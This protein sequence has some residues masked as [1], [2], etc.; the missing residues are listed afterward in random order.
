M[1][2]AKPKINVKSYGSIFGD[3]PANEPNA[4]DIVNV[5]LNKL[6]SFDKHPFKVRDDDDMSEL[7]ASIAAEGV[8]NPILV[9]AY[10]ADG[11]YQIIA[12]HRRKR[13]AEIAGLTVIPAIVRDLDDDAAIAFMVDTNLARTK[14]LPSEKAWAYKMK[15]D[16]MKR[17]AGRKNSNF[18]PLEQNYPN[19]SSREQLAEQ[20]GESQAQ[21]RRYIRLTELIPAL[22]N[23]ADAEQ[24]SVRAGVE[25]SYIPGAEQELIESQIAEYEDSTSKIFTLSMKHAEALRSFAERLDEERVRGILFGLPK[26]KAPVPAKLKLNAS[27]IRGFFPDDA[28]PDEIEETI[29]RLLERWRDG[30]VTA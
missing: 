10:G 25:L 29:I 20:S 21:I 14:I 4:A 2:N 27:R 22:L 8:M 13:A 24:I 26:A 12:G 16:A 9:R 11:E 1:A 6:R 15:L 30:E 5:A 19:F 7:A 23:R 18:V 17:Q 28:E 3:E